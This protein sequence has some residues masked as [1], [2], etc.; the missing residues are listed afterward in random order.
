MP[1]LRRLGAEAL[2]SLFLL[3]GVVGSGIMGETLS[4]E[5]AAVA[6][7]GNTLATGALL[8]V[9]TRVLGPLSGAHLNPAV[10][11]ALARALGLWRKDG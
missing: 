10:A 3:A 5:N 8:V 1:P 7:L 9:L 4:P 11:L 2:G 6:L